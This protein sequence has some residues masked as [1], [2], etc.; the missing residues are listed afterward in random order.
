MFTKNTKLD[1]LLWD[2]ILSVYLVGKQT[3]KSDLALRASWSAKGGTGCDMAQPSTG[4]GAALDAGCWTLNAVG[5]AAHTKRKRWRF[6]RAAPSLRSL[7]PRPQQWQ[8]LRWWLWCLLWQ[9][10]RS[11]KPRLQLQCPLCARQNQAFRSW[12]P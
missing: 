8:Q 10:L 7:R 2:T 4:R 5:H 3:S 12:W 1:Y 6:G 9:Q 11:A